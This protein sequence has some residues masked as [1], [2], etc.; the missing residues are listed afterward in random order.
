M[1]PLTK[2]LLTVNEAAYVLNCSGATIYK[3][4][5][6]GKVRYYKHGRAYRIAIEDIISY[7]SSVLTTNNPDNNPKK[8]E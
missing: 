5:K 3:M 7:I 1:F 2:L 4:I 8:P 6:E